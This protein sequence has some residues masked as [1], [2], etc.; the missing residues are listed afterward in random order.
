MTLSAQNKAY[1]D[2][3]RDRIKRK[4]VE[5]NEEDLLKLSSVY[6]QVLEFSGIKGGGK[7][8]KS[9]SSCIMEPVKILFNYITYHE[10]VVPVH[11]AT[12]V[13][14]VKPVVVFDSELPV[15]T[16]IAT[17]EKTTPVIE[18]GNDNTFPE[19]VKELPEKESPVKHVVS[20]EK[21]QGPFSSEPPV[22]K[23]RRPRTV[24]PKK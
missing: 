18:W 9:C 8:D 2:E 24:K 21:P 7:I 14:E 6:G 19:K 16:N 17:G 11:R 5:Y 3:L 1:L 4:H 20:N 12:I 22:K 23:T 13:K 10:P 15:L